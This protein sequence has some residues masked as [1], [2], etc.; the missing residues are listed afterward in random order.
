MTSDW[1]KQKPGA[2]RHHHN[3]H[4]SDGSDGRL[5][6]CVMWQASTSF[7]TTY[8]QF[9]DYHPSLC[10]N[11]QAPPLSP[12][13]EPGLSGNQDARTLIKCRNLWERE[14]TW[15]L[16]LANRN[17]WNLIKRVDSSRRVFFLCCKSSNKK[18]CCCRHNILDGPAA[19]GA[20]CTHFILRPRGFFES[21]GLQ[22]YWNS[23]T[24]TPPVHVEYIWWREIP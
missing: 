2:V 3:W 7:T 17:I 10:F 11:I 8:W 14:A 22:L 13:K 9:I 4:G 19:A 23:T 24:R 18:P 16:L 6:E 1:R 20:L 15:L 12:E 21:H 5:K